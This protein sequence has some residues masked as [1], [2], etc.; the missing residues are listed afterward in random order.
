M[1]EFIKSKLGLLL[2]TGFALISVALI[3][4]ANVCGNDV[5]GY[6]ALI[7]TLPWSLLGFFDL[8]PAMGSI[9]FYCSFIINTVIVYI[10]TVSIQ[11]FIS[12]KN[13]KIQ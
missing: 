3:I 7:P 8:S 2:A 6:V 4:Y 12:A 1:N 5:C 10:I 13:R 11:K 9:V